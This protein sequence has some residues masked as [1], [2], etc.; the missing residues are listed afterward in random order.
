MNL[1][2][3]TD[4]IS[5]IRKGRLRWL[6]HVIRVPEERTV[7]RVFKN[8]PDRKCSV[9]NPRKRWLVD[10]DNNLKKMSVRGCRKIA[11]DRDAW[12]FVLK[13]A[14]IMHRP[15]KQ[16]RRELRLSKWAS[17]ALAQRA[18]YFGRKNLKSRRLKYIKHIGIISFHL[19]RYYSL[20]AISNMRLIT[21]EIKIYKNIQI[22]PLCGQSAGGG[23]SVPCCRRRKP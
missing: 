15:Y 5:G 11:R 10:V 14:R 8:I 1:N 17:G 16:W 12:K 3:E 4:I 13:G 9:G 2:R 18:V 19:D 20:F 21:C 6:G 7:K 22:Y 23:N